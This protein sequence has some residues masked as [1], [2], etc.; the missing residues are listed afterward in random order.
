MGKGLQRAF[1]AAQATQKPKRRI[2]ENAWGNWY[3]YEGNRMTTP[4]FNT[5]THTQ[6]QE[7]EYWLEHGKLPD[8]N[9]P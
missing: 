4:F 1:A 7:A 8:P 6:K 9:D 5:P 2:K 3:G